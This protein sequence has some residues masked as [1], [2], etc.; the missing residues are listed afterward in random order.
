MM[1][2]QALSALTI[3]GSDPS[4]GAGI[5]IDL[6]TFASTGVWGMAVITGLTAQNACRVAGVWPVDPGIVSIQIATLL[7]DMTP[8][9]VKTGMLAD[10][11]I[12][13]AVD[14]ALPPLCRLVVDP[15]MVS[16]SGHRLLAEPAVRAVRDILIPR[17]LLVTPN[18]PEAEVLTGFPITGEEGMEEAGRAILSLG[19]EAVVVKGG[20]GSGETAVDL[21][22]TRTQ[23]QRLVAPR[24]PYGVHGSGCCFSAAVTGFLARGSGLEEACRRGKELVTRAIQ[25]AVCGAGGVRMV[26]P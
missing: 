16:T 23:V 21:L 14:R 11:A 5:Q 13:R 26:N 22:V 25:G 17:A 19:A 20:H 4:G 7:E 9:A 18:I 15:V 6:K 3:A 12:I 10:E 8:G 1:G 2:D 24:L